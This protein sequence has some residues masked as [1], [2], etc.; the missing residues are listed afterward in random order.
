MLLFVPLVDGSIGET[1]N[2]QSMQVAELSVL[3]DN[4]LQ[5]IINN[6]FYSVFDKR[7]GF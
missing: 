3:P 2:Q 7:I 6:L 4:I 1:A 5:Y